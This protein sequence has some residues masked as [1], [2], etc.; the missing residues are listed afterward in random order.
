MTCFICFDVLY[1][2]KDIRDLGAAVFPVAFPAAVGS[3]VA[4]VFTGSS[5]MQGNTLSSGGVFRRI[6][7][8]S[9]QLHENGI[10]QQQKHA[11]HPIE[12]RCRFMSHCQR[13]RAPARHRNL[14][15]DKAFMASL[16]AAA[17]FSESFT[18]HAG[19]FHN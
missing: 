2:Y 19:K 1:F 7:S 10:Y 5:S 16:R 8:G 15:A 12:R 17:S 11:W 3:C 4:S 14:L 18:E 13:Q 6:V 9:R